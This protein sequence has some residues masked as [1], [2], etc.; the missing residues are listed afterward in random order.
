MARHLLDFGDVLWRQPVVHLL[1]KL[2]DL[3]WAGLGDALYGEPHPVT[4]GELRRLDGLEDPILKNRLD[5]TL[6]ADPLSTPPF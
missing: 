2:E 6:H 3:V 4:L 5:R 1:G